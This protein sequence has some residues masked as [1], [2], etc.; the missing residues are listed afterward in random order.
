MLTC[1]CCAV[2]VARGL[3]WAVERAAPLSLTRSS[4][5]DRC[6]LPL[7]R[8]TNHATAD[9]QLEQLEHA[10]GALRRS[11]SRRI[12]RR[13]RSRRRRRRLVRRWRSR[14]LLQR[15]S[16]CSSGRWSESKEKSQ[17]T[18]NSSSSAA[19]LARRRRCLRS[20]A[21]LALCPLALCVCL[22]SAICRSLPSQRSRSEK[23]HGNPLREEERGMD[24]ACRRSEIKH[25]ATRE[26]S[27]LE[28]A[29]PQIQLA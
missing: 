21:P 8:A 4:S 24:R 26:E 12:R 13:R 27:Q 15:S 10:D 22:F 20:S 3:C 11:H 23:H 18:R 5:L 6:R 7:E 9:T 29:R 14:F 17:N 25:T 16:S 2:H 19:A 28:C 1:R